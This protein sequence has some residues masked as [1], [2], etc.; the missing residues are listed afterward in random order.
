MDPYA[1]LK[2]IDF[3]FDTQKFHLTDEQKRIVSENEERKGK[4]LDEK[5]RVLDYVDYCNGEDDDDLTTTTTTTNPSTTDDGD[6]D[7]TEYLDC[8]A[9]GRKTSTISWNYDVA[10]GSA[11]ITNID[12]GNSVTCT[13]CFASMGE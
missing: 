5:G 6:D 8:I 1:I 2:R 12:L 9:L 7:N 11:S 10:T 4:M 13:N 3:N